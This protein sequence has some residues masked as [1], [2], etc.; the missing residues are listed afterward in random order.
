MKKIMI[1]VMLFFSLTLPLFATSEEFYE[2]ITNADE[3]NGEDWINFAR[4]EKLSYLF[5]L[6]AALNFSEGIAY[7][8]NCKVVVKAISSSFF[9]I[10]G[11]TYGTL[12]D[13]TDEFYS[14]PA[15][16]LIPV[17]GAEFYCI[18]K[19]KGSPPDVL[20]NIILSLRQEAARLKI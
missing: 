17:I 7:Y 15:N 10:T 11:V 20:T 2:I 14:D 5:G 16:R 19:L 8:T 18:Q 13:M 3:I 12:I 4:E 9:D 1:L 6:S